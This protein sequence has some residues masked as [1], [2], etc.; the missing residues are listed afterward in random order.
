MRNRL[1]NVISVKTKAD[2]TTNNTTKMP[3]FR[4]W[5][6]ENIEN[7]WHNLQTIS[8][9]VW[10]KDL[11]HGVLTTIKTSMTFQKST[12]TALAFSGSLYSL[13]WKKNRSM[14]L[15]RDDL[16]DSTHYQVVSTWNFDLKNILIVSF[17]TT[18]CNLKFR[19]FFRMSFFRDILDQ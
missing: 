11:L 15:S 18:Y 7:S 5:V 10:K 16:L 9:L 8:K 14:H 19:Q 3:P 12:S 1:R 2:L 4:L 17:L 13:S 6:I